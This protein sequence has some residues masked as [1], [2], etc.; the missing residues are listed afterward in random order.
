MWRFPAALIAVV[1]SSTWFHVASPAP[2]IARRP[3]PESIVGRW[4][5]TIA[6]PD[7]ALPS[8]LEVRPSGNGWAPIARSTGIEP[9]PGE[10]GRS[11]WFWL[12]GITAVYSIMFAAGGVIFH[13]PR[14]AATFGALLLVSGTLLIYGIARE[15]A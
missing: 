9:P 4:D 14:Q 11:F 13:L 7:R 15:K 2:D 5:I 1:A 6:G 3:S 12:L 10:I 8:W